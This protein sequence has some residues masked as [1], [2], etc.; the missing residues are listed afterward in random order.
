MTDIPIQV[1][2]WHLEYR[3]DG[4]NKFYSI[5]LDETHNRIWLAWGRI[6]TDGQDK[7]STFENAQDAKAKALA[8][9]YAKQ[10]KGYELV[11]DDVV[12]EVEPVTFESRYRLARETRLAISS[13]AAEPREAALNYIEGFVTDCNEFLVRAKEGTDADELAEWFD[14]LNGRWEELKDKHDSA[15]TMMH[16][17]KMRALKRA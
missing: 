12:F 7:P 16:M 9:V 15:E 10:S 6:G 8:Q 13:G 2:H 1:R 11:T 17:V 14:D 3:K 4:S 5:W